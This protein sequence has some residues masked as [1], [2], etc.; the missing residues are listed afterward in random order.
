MKV[1]VEDLAEVEVVAWPATYVARSFILQPVTCTQTMTR[2]Q[3]FLV[4]N[5]LALAN[6]NTIQLIPVEN[7]LVKPPLL[8]TPGFTNW[9]WRMLVNKEKML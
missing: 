6:H 9:C 8:K 2:I 1:E 5:P 7:L 4:N 3:S